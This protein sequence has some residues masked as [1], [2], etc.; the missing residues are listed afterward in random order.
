MRAREFIMESQTATADEIWRYVQQLHPADQQGGGFLERLVQ[1]YPRYELRTVPLADLHIPDQEYDDQEQDIEDDPH[2]RTLSV[3]PDHAGEYSQ[4]HVDRSPIVVD[5]NG[6]ILDGNHR[7]WAAAELLGRDTIRAWV[8]VEQ[9]SEI[10]DERLQRY[11]S[12]ADR[13]VSTRLDRMT[14]A[15]ERLNKSWEIYDHNN[16]KRIIDRFEANTP[17]EAQRYYQNFIDNYNPGDE[18]FE[19]YLRRSTGILEQQEL[20]EIGDTRTEYQP[21]RKRNRSLFHAT[22]DGY[23]VDVHFDKSFTGSLQITFTVNQNYEPRQHR[24]IDQGTVFRI[25]SAVQQIIKERLPEYM[26]TARP[27]RVTFT[28]KGD[29]RVKLYRRM[30]VPLVTE[31]LGPKWQ[32]SE[33]PG[34]LYLFVWEPVKKQQVGEVLNSQAGP[35]SQWNTADPDMISLDFVASNGVPYQLDFLA[36][37]IGADEMSPY[38]FFNDVSDKAYDRS[39][40]V[41]F[42]Q[43]QNAGDWRHEE[44]KSG[45]EGTG[46]A[47]E[48]LGIVANAMVQYVKTYRPSML[49]FQAAEPNRQSVYARMLP[50]IAQALPG[51]RYRRQDGQHFV[52]YNQKTMSSQQPGAKS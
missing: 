43:I 31:I 50:R 30:F 37:H 20:N 10:S 44:I 26:R 39:R 28:A 11:L 7:A 5:A 33:H 40:Y 15:R 45:I 34:E 2:G 21:N 49:Y 16:P 32:L 38:T 12:R 35:Q 3:D 51:W 36:P 4:Y 24:K 8:P 22:V 1:Q 9:L 23:W 41:S 19:F 6:Y 29:S 27:P 48:V 13:Q 17:A 42:Y 25:F 46:S 14:R 18:N 47:A 52:I